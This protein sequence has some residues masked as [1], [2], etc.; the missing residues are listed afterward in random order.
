M[1]KL[2]ILLG[3]LIFMPSL[4]L[5]NYGN[6]SI[7]AVSI[8]VTALE[9]FQAAV[10]Q[11]SAAWS[12][13]LVNHSTRLTSIE[14]DSITI[15]TDLNTIVAFNADVRTTS[16][17]VQLQLNDFK[18]SSAA[19]SITLVNHSTRLTNL[20]SDSITIHIDLNAYG[21]TLGTHNTALY[22]LALSTK[23]VTDNQA[24]WSTHPYEIIIDTPMVGTKVYQI[25]KTSFTL[26]DVTAYSGVC[27]TGA[28][29]TITVTTATMSGNTTWLSGTSLGTLTIADGKVQ[30][31]TLALTQY[32]AKDNAAVIYEITAIGS[33]IP[34]YNIMI[35]GLKTW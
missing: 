1:K 13:T 26:G 20:E 21:S 28:A 31:N 30:S 35:S 8:R 4:I 7:G 15:H 29:L 3:L 12:L 34:G 9:V 25:L 24:S 19:W 11:S 27:P 17:A 6:G 16:A 33:T 10:I 14:S 5:A 23:I 32:V 22:N 18:V 2:F